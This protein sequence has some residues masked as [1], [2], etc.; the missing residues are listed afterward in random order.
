[1]EL[2][3]LELLVA[4]ELQSA[5]AGGA[6]VGQAAALEAEVL[7]AAR[8]PAVAPGPPL[9]GPPAEV[10]ATV[11]GTPGWRGLGID[12]VE[13]DP[14]R[15]PDRHRVVRQGPGERE[16]LVGTGAGHDADPGHLPGAEPANYLGFPRSF[17]WVDSRFANMAFAS[18]SADRLL[19]ML[20]IPEIT[21]EFDCLMQPQLYPM[22]VIL[23]GE[24][25]SGMAG[26]PFYVMSVTNTWNLVP[27]EGGF[28]NV[29]R[30]HVSGRFLV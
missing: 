30:S 29:C 4:E 12:H 19:Q 7:G 25:R 17:I 27:G 10:G 11:A 13:V 5:L 23:I 2:G 15:G 20:R 28:K 18:L 14:L 22:D 1:V 9:G 24:S 6:T 16:Q 8:V 26:I 21:V 3:D